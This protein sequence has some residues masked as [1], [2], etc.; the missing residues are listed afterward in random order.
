M[1]ESRRGIDTHYCL[2]T[3]ASQ[4]E[5]TDGKK[6]MTEASKDRPC[7]IAGCPGTYEAGR[8]V[9]TVRHRGEIIVI[10]N[11]PAEIC[12]ICGDV[13]FTPE[14]T[15][16]IQTIIRERSRPTVGHAPIYEFA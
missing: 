12:T 13:L 3:D 10:E 14:T 9:H 1:Y 7:S 4:V 5:I 15:E 2:R 6:Q 16:R 8:V 11:V